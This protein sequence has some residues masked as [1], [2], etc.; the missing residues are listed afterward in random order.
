VKPDVRSLGP[1]PRTLARALA[2]EG[3]DGGGSGGTLRLTQV[4]FEL[5]RAFVAEG[6]R[7]VASSLLA[8]V[9]RPARAGGPPSLLLNAHVHLWPPSARSGAPRPVAEA[10]WL[11]A[12]IERF[13]ARGWR[14]SWDPGSGRFGWIARPLDGGLEPLTAERAFLEACFGGTV[15]GMAG[16]ARR[17]AGADAGGAPMLEALRILDARGWRFSAMEAGRRAVA[18]PEVGGTLALA[19]R[20]EGPPAER[21]D[22]SRPPR[23]VTTITLWPAASSP[24]GRPARRPHPW[25]RHLVAEARAAGLRGGWRI[26]PQG[27]Q[28]LTLSAR[29]PAGTATLRHHRKLLDAIP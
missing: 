15:G 10:P 25:V 3:G 26:P 27:Q 12:E 18:P 20:V 6:G 2:P 29:R 4:R 28:V 19:I 22:S 1:R 13:E 24:T 8:C 14:V 21:R 9:E 7:W 17:V 5:R 11:R 23:M 16:D